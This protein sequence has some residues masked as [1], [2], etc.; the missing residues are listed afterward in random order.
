[1]HVHPGDLPYA[2]PVLRAASPSGSINTE[3]GPDETSQSD[4]DLSPEEFE[5][6]VAMSLGLHEQREHEISAESKS[7]LLP[8]PKSAAEEKLMFEQVMRSLRWHVQ[9]LE[10]N[11]MI[12][13]MLLQGSR[14]ALETQPSSD[15]V[16]AIMQTMMGP[17]LS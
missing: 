15:N 1:H 11:E 2:T 10:E 13:S 3:Y 9:Q 5:E 6:K 14:I 7:L 17:P 12:E 8:K 16:D 4:L